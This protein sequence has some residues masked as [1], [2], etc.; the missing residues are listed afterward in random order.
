MVDPADAVRLL[1]EALTRTCISGLVSGANVSPGV[2]VRRISNQK[3]KRSSTA[4]EKNNRAKT[5]A[6][7]SSPKVVITSPPFGPI[8][9]IVVVDDDGKAS[10]DGASLHIRRHSSSTQ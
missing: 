4:G 2:T 5:I 7:E 9:D 3:E 6:P 1:Q 10:D 8:I